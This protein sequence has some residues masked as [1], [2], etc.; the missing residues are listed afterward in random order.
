M[1]NSTHILGLIL[2]YQT[3]KN[4][5]HIRLLYACV[6]NNLN[7][8]YISTNTPFQTIY[9][10]IYICSLKIDHANYSLKSNMPLLSKHGSAPYRRR[11]SPTFSI[12]PKVLLFHS[13]SAAFTFI[14][15]PIT[16][17]KCPFSFNL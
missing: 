13:K 10:Y 6:F 8:L 7:E 14:R 11:R 16:L 15:A 1:R 12:S 5:S 9:R 2:L 4:R 17:L 3:K